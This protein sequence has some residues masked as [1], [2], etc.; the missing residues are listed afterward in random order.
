MSGAIA[1][2]GA[3]LRDSAQL[4]EARN[5]RRLRTALRSGLRG[6]VAAPLVFA[7]SVGTMA[8]GL[9]MLSAYLLVVQNVRGV[10]TSY[11]EELNLVAFL[12]RGP[13]EGGVSRL[14]KEILAR[15]EVSEVAFVSSEQALARLRRDLG[16][17]ADVLEGLE[18]NP[19]P[20]SFEIAL[21]ESAREPAQLAALARRLK[22]LPAI[23]DVR[24]GE[25]WVESYARM[26]AALEWIGAALGACLVLVL[27]VIVAGTVRLAV[28]ARTDEI[29]IQRLVGAGSFFVRLPFYVEAGLQGAL[30][31]A[32]ALGLLYAFYA[33]ALPLIGDTL[34]RMFGLPSPSFFGTLEVSALLLLGVLLGVGAA[35]LSLMRLEQA[36]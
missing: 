20:A 18:A 26:L 36:H 13:V 1:R 30:G 22:G 9:L 25:A 27:G 24:Y 28:Y 12:D 3:L 16:A 5:L 29:Q 14:A 4:L 15:P 7:L 21:V 23:E 6:I 35:A 33:L 8:A 32:A 11:G 19:L 34:L 10:L 17:D 31:A 2:G